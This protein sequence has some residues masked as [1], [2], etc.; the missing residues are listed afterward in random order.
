MSNDTMTA[1][2]TVETDQQQDPEVVISP[3]PKMVDT[4]LYTC[5]LQTFGEKTPYVGMYWYDIQFKSVQA[6]RDHFSTLVKVG[7]N[8][9]DLIVSLFNSRINGMLRTKMTTGVIP[10]SVKEREKLFNGEEHALIFPVEEV[11]R[12]VP[13]KSEPYSLSGIEKELK[14]LAELLN[15]ERA[16]GND[17]DQTKMT[18]WKAEGKTLFKKREELAAK[19]SDP[20]N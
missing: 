14:N 4:E 20:F 13:G 2:T 10:E 3:Y 16:K 15:T 18:A 17:A 7:E 8:T 1:P 12:Y 19:L 9:D 5:N 6:I 11:T